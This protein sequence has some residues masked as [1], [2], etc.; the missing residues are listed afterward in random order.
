MN[1][2]KDAHK[3][4]KEKLKSLAG[5]LKEKDSGQSADNSRFRCTCLISNRENLQASNSKIWTCRSK[6]VRNS[7]TSGVMNTKWCAGTSI[8]VSIN[9]NQ[10]HALKTMS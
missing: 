1:S 10:K 7:P 6:G 3:L 9:P 2:T 5:G 8:R 4:Q